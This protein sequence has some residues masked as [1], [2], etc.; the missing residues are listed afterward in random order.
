MYMNSFKAQS[1][2]TWAAVLTP[3]PS[4]EMLTGN[5]F[6]TG[7]VE[8]TQYDQAYLVVLCDFP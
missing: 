6:C 5:V 4:L 2:G 1:E 3:A 8:Q 7:G